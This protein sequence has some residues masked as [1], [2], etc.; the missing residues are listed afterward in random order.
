MTHQYRIDQHGPYRR[1]IVV[2]NGVDIS[3]HATQ[4]EAQAA[5]EALR[6]RSQTTEPG[7][8]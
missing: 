2:R 5:L 6:S 3:A 8:G 4:A 7:E 1:W